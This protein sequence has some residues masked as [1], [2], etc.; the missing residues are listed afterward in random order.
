M[1][2]DNPLWHY[3][4]AVYSQAEIETI[5]LEVQ[6]HGLQVNSVLCCIWLAQQ[7]KRYDSSVFEAAQQPWRNKFLLPFREMRYALRLEKAQQAI[8][9]S[10][11]ESMKDTE[12]AMEQ[13]DIALLWQASNHLT[14][15]DTPPTE[16]VLALDN[17]EVYIQS[18][19]VMNPDIC[20]VGCRSL[21]KHLC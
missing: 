14:K 1:K 18:E 11:Y 20:R 12:L 6:G 4:S 2:L 5:C 16:A 8:L 9:S 19:N 3:I 15:V 21:V 7:Q 17:L 13:V 10:C